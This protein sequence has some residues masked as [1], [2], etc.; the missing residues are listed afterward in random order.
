VIKMSY[1]YYGTLLEAN[2]YF[3]AR[4][5]EDIWTDTSDTDR[6]KALQAATRIIDNLNF[7]GEKA[8]VY[9][10][11]YDS[12]GNELTYT[13]AD[14]RTADLSQPL[15]FPRTTDTDVP[16]QIK[17]ACWEIAYALLDEIDPDLEL[18]N[19]AVT[20]QSIASIRTSY[21]RVNSQIEHVVNGI[22]SATA[23]RYLR[24]FL[25]DSEAII[26]SRVD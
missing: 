19:L 14:L 24:P 17:M 23:W 2:D 9:S 6:E 12:G 11:M 16:D 7:K 4:L 22:P 8:A 20:S 21:D 3:D 15:E 26:L 13:D 25:R 18:E 10:V 5:H 1:T